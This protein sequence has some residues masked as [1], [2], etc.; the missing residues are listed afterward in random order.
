MTILEHQ[1][2]RNQAAFACNQNGR[3]VAWNE[4]A[5]QFLGHA[6]AE[7]IGRHCFEVLDGRDVFGNRFCHE[8]CA[9]RSMIRRQEPINQ[10]Q[11]NYRTAAGARIDVSVSAVLVNG[12]KGAECVVVHVLKPVETSGDELGP[13]TADEP[14]GRLALEDSV[15]TGAD[16]VKLTIRERQILRMLASGSNTSEIVDRLYISANT[17]RTHIRNIIHKLNAHSRLEA[18]SRAI[19]KR[20]L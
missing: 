6:S 15:D 11:L 14:T 10:W 9:I 2:R 20:L 1:S 16:P 4:C 7:M 5:E 13:G 18:V 19:R 12:G 8:R 3:I 17:V